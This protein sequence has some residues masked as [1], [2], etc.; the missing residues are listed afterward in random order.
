MRT[1][2]THGFTL[3]ELLVVI[4]IIGVLIAL[5]LPAVQAAREAARRIQCKNHLKQIGVAFQ[6]HHSSFN[7][8]PTGGWGRYWLGEPE[9]GT[10]RNQPGGWAFNILDQLEQRNTR[11]LGEG[12]RGAAR[13]AA[14]AERCAT[15]ISVFNCPSRRGPQPLPDTSMHRYCTIDSSSLDFEEAGRGDYAANAGDQGTVEYEE[16]SSG[17]VPGTYAQG[18]NP[19]W[20][21]P[22]TTDLMGVVFLRS[23]ISTNDITD[24]TSCTYLVGEK[25]LCVEG[26]VIPISKGDRESLYV[27]FGNDTCRTAYY[28]PARDPELRDGLAGEERRFGSAHPAGFQCVFCDGSVR[29]IEYEVDNRVHRCMANREDGEVVVP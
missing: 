27:G 7:R 12:A 23:E 10:D 4:A 3:V 18:I 24:G 22:D 1:R 6:S 29:M 16:G 25:C 20:I 5:L 15:A 26:Y 14:F 8:F 19:S 11:N 9:L 2:R 13:A 28:P 21:W 17:K